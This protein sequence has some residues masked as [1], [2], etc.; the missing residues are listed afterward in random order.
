MRLASRQVLIIVIAAFVGA[1]LGFVAGVWFAQFSD[2]EVRKAAMAQMDWRAHA[3]AQVTQPKSKLEQPQFIAHNVTELTQHLGDRSAQRFL[4]DAKRSLLIRR[5]DDIIEDPWGQPYIFYFCT[6]GSQ[7]L[8]I[9]NVHKIFG[10]SDAT[11]WVS[12]C[13]VVVVSTTKG[14]IFSGATGGQQLQHFRKD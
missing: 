8:S 10:N 3:L 6:N 5:R 11:L 9:E 7:T 4:T 13:D 1:M 12:G 14:L 2:N